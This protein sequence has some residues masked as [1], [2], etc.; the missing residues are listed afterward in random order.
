MSVNSF[1]VNDFFSSMENRRLSAQQMSNKWK[2]AVW[3]KDSI[4]PAMLRLNVEYT[5]LIY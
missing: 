2:E 5:Y 4:E 3:D 1:Q